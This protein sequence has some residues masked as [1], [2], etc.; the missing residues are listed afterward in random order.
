[1]SDQE[2]RENNKRLKER[3]VALAE[4]PQAAGMDWEVLGMD[5]FHAGYVLNAG[6]CFVRADECRQRESLPV[7]VGE[8][9]AV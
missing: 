4:N 1:M 9:E 3:F 2:R 7:V 8:L 6:V 5:Y